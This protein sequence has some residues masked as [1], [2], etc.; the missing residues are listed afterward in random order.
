MAEIGMKIRSTAP[1]VIFCGCLSTTTAQELS[2]KLYAAIG[3]DVP[4]EHISIIATGANYNALVLL[5]REILAPFL[6]MCLKSVGETIKMSPAISKT[7]KKAERMPTVTKRMDRSNVTEQC[8]STIG[9]MVL[10]KA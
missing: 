4:V 8:R 1:V 6:E 2:D 3:L 7:E 5:D 10:S 9:D